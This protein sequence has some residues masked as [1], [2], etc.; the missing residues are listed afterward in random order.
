MTMADAGCGGDDI[1]IQV[2]TQYTCT[3]SATAAVAAVADTGSYRLFT[4]IMT[5]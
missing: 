4:T 1:H 2:F 3:V 5:Y